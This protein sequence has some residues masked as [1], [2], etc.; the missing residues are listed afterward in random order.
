M[1]SKHGSQN[2]LRDISIVLRNAIF[3]PGDYI[4]YK[5]DVG[6]E[7]YFIA[8]GTVFVIGEDKRTVFTTLGRGQYFGEMAMFLES[9]KRTAYVQA[10]T[11][12]NI[13]ILRKKDLDR[14]MINFSKIIEEFKEEAE[15]RSKEI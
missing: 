14:L 11:F 6:D 8:E 15:R 3:L 5:D 4:I 1:F 7:M 13:S 9:N 12:C 10:E 2:F